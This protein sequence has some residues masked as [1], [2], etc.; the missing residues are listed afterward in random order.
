MNAERL[1]YCRYYKG[2]GEPT[3]EEGF[4]EYYFAKAEQFYVN[5]YY[6]KDEQHCVEL[7]KSLHLEDLA[8]EV[9]FELVAFLFGM[10]DHIAQR[11]AWDFCPREEVARR[12]REKFFPKYL[13]RKL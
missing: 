5:E 8:G 7:A 6:S 11:G 9:P 3:D 10:C 13:S 12:F 1:K 2:S 4:E